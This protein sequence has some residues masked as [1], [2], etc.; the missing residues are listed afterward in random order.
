MGEYFVG[1]VTWGFAAYL[2]FFN[3]DA[4]W[5]GFSVACWIGR[6]VIIFFLPTSC[7]IR[8]VGDSLQYDF[9]I[10]CPFCIV[11]FVVLI[12]EVVEVV[13]GSLANG[14]TFVSCSIEIWFLL[15]KA[16]FSVV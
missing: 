7:S 9:V 12:G 11:L 8:F 4:D 13:M 14:E 6:L 10:F 1:G 2:R 3:G 5:Y 15:I 16:K